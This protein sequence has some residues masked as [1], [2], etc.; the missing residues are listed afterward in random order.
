MWNISY[1]DAHCDTISRRDLWTLRRYEGQLDLSRLHEFAT[2]GQIFAIFAPSG[3][4]KPEELYNITR[5]QR[6]RFADEI[7]ANSDIAVHCRTAADAEQAFRDRKV[8]AFLSIEGA[9]LL[10]CDVNLL[11]EVADWGVRSINL[12]WNYPNAV[13]GTNAQEPERGLSDIGRNFV[14]E[15]Q[16]RNILMDVSHLSEKGFWDLVDITNAPIIASHSNAKALCP[17]SRNLTDE[18]I[19]AVVAT[20]GFVGLNFYSLFVGERADMDELI[21]HVEHFWDLGAENVLGLGGD[22]DGCDSLAGGFSGIQ[23]MPKLYEALY[24]RNHSEELLQK[25]FGGNLLRVLK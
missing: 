2:A 11:D 17:H 23:D 1:F 7:A 19:R 18:Q 12:T 22:W 4:F 16:K 15:A 3:Y 25:F 24:R 8:A 5:S 20:N 10:N 21:A 14:K 9:E 6:Q 13:S